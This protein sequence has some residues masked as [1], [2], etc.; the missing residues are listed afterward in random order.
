MLGCAHIQL[1]YVIWYVKACNNDNVNSSSFV[2]SMPTLMTPISS[3][4]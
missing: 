4:Q 1:K 2:S 3:A